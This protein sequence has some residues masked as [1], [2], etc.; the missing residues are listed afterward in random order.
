MST[1]FTAAAPP[2]ITAAR[3]TDGFWRGVLR[4]MG[5][6]WSV[7]V[8]AA[9]LLTIVLLAV[10]APWLAPHDPFETAML[11]RLKPLGSSGFPLGTDELGRDMLSRLMHGA[12]LSLF[13]A[14]VPVLLAFVLGTT[15]GV[16]AGYFG[17]RVNTVLMR[18]MDVF[19][20]FP[21]V[22]L[23]IAIAGALGS[24]LANVVASL[25]LV[26]VP[27]IARVA[28]SVTTQVRALPYIDAAR[29]SGASHFAIIRV[30]LLANVMGPVF[31]Y[32]SSLLSVAIILASGLSF[33]GLGVKPPQA[34]WGVMLNTL[35]T[36][37]YSQP[38]VAVLPGVAIFA[39]SMCC[40][41]ISDGLRTAMDVKS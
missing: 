10:L 13:M 29:I 8:P 30:H 32:A 24:G 3:G 15:I 5:R 19:F 6:N 11:G 17:G 23:A 4:R 27:P 35:R 7:G 39:T 14:F 2:A 21:S 18:S 16:V 22:L 9:V 1:T 28:E 34:E 38:W 26:F 12:R 40:N 36:A 37:I 31:V 20:A 41:L 33:L 25:T